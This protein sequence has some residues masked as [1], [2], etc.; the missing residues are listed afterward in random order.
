MLHSK[1]K[2]YISFG[3]F[4]LKYKINLIKCFQ[5]NSEKYSN[6][7]SS[8]RFAAGAVAPPVVPPPR[9]RPWFSSPLDC[10]LRLIMDAFR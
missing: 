7:H 9:S 4:N 2:N 5:L 1:I 6:L 10:E 8:E 3:L